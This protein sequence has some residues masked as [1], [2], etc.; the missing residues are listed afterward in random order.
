[1]LSKFLARII[2]PSALKSSIHHC[3]V[4]TSIIV[5]KK[6]EFADTPPHHS[7]P[8]HKSLLS[9]QLCNYPPYQQIK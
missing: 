1:M 6:V 5:P 2:A 3:P 8:D 9:K 7:G 4:P